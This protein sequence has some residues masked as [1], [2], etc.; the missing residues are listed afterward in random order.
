[1]STVA[2]RPRGPRVA[3]PIL[4]LAATMAFATAAGPDDPPASEGPPP[5]PAAAGPLEAADRATLLGI[6]WRTLEGALTGTPIQTSDLAAYT[7]GGH[8]QEPRGCWITLRVAGMVR[9]SMGE[10]EAGRPLYQQVIF[11]TRRAATRDARFAPLVD[12]DLP[13]ITVEIALI[14][15]RRV[16]TDAANLAVGGRG[17]YLE[18]WG[19]RAIFLPGVAASQGWDGERALKAL[20]RQ[21]AL[22]ED[23]WMSGARIETFD[24][25]LISGPRPA[26]ATPPAPAGT[27][28]ATPPGS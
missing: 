12:A 5:A 10:I 18:K 20:A 23:G 8:L 21:A 11:H 19:R 24:A 13:A 22:P 3:I 4:L 6:A 2:R 16:V 1:V 14:G 17:L 28:P 9:G 15:S 27:P 26:P 25:E 7:I